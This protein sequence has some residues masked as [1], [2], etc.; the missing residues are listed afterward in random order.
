[1]LSREGGTDAVAD[2]SESLRAIPREQFTADS[3]AVVDYLKALPEVTR[4]GII[5]F[6]FGGGVTWR[7]ATECPDIVAAVPCYG[8]NPPL[9]NVPNTNAAIFAIYGGLDERVNAGIP[10]INAVL[11][12]AGVTHS[13]KVYPESLHAFMSHNSEASYNPDTA[14]VAWADALAWFD[15]YLMS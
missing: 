3:I 1:M 11:D 5:G 2:A 12:A 7:V 6:C 13:H 15:K 9:E 8:S 4:I 10:E 14:P